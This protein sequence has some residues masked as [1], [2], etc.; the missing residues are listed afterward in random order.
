MGCRDVGAVGRGG[1]KDSDV[2]GWVAGEDG[3]KWKT[4]VL[5]NSGV[6]RQ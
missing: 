5:G 3:S 4:D 6:D 1:W 2:V